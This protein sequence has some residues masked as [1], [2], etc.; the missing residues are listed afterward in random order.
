MSDRDGNRLLAFASDDL[1]ATGSPTPRVVI[2][3]GA[4]LANPTA[5][6]FDA[7]GRLWVGNRGNATVVGFTPDQLAASGN[8]TPAVTLRDDGSGDLDG[9]DGLAFDAGGQLWVASRFRDLLLA[10][11]DPGSLSGDA[12]V[13]ADVRIA[14]DD[15]AP[16]LS[17]PAG[18][19]FDAEG[20]LWVANADAAGVVR[21]DAASLR[22][23]GTPRPAVTLAS[24]GADLVAPG[25]LAFD[26]DGDLWVS[27]AGGSLT[28][29]AAIDLA[30]SGTPAPAATLAGLAGM[31]EGFLAF[32]P[33]PEGL[34]LAR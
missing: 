33:P 7:D 21:F 3:P 34:P 31:D 13:S 25:G 23:S 8:P 9:P 14:N 2:G 28:K 32:S 1:G 19:A 5:L 6:A 20:G 26:A 12:T 24:D 18:L 17:A 10:Y 22:V 16:T 15:A 29:L 27:N 4:E 11:A 30:T